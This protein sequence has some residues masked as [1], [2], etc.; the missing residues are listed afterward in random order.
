MKI[1]DFQGKKLWSQ[2]QKI[3]TPVNTG[4]IAFRT[5]TGK[6]ISQMDTSKIVFVA[7][8]W[9]GKELMASNQLYFAAPKNLSLEKPEIIKKIVSNGNNYTI[10]LTSG[11]LVKNLYLSIEDEGKFSDNYFDIMPG[12]TKVI[13]FKSIGEIANFENKLTLVSLVDSY[14]K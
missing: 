13:T 5:S 10:S 1:V 4:T 6:L 3:N 14:T 2:T 9:K 12:E 11:N 7:K 8:L